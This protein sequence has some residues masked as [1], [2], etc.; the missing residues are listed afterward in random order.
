MALAK[1]V[2]HSDALNTQATD[3]QDFPRPYEPTDAELAHAERV[4]NTKKSKQRRV[5]MNLVERL[6]KV[7]PVEESALAGR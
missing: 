6:K 5:P 4:L 7:E 2:E 3:D 1:N